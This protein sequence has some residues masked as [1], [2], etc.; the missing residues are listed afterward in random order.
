MFTNDMPKMAGKERE[1]MAVGSRFSSFLVVSC[2]LREIGG[3]G[4][5]TVVLDVLD[6][7]SD[8]LKQPSTLL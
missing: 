5:V 1:F 6:D 3:D 2:R 8:C 7:A 4:L